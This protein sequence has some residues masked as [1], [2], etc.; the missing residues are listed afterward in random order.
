MNK[1]LN[2]VYKC[3]PLSEVGA[4]QMLL[5]TMSLKNCFI[6]MTILGS[7]PGSQPPAT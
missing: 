5:D 2:I 6:Q 1:Y 3:K 7:E 4:E